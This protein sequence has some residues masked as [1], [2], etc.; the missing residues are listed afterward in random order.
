MEKL[1]GSAPDYIKENKWI[2]IKSCDHLYLTYQIKLLTYMTTQYNAKLIIS[3]SK[4]CIASDLLLDFIQKYS[5][6]IALERRSK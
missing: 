4:D 2:L 6:Y 1:R 5:Q 3:I